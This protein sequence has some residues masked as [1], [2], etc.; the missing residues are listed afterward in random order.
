[1]TTYIVYVPVLLWDGEKD[2]EVKIV[3]NSNKATL[4][5]NKK[6]YETIECDFDI[7]SIVNELNKNF[8]EEIVKTL[9]E[10]P[11]KVDEVEKNMMK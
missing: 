4:R 11:E 3:L 5:A 9:K 10:N 6:D 7:E 1:M 8:L 2:I